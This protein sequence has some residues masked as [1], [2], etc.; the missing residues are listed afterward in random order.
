M[1][2]PTAQLAGI[3]IGTS[4]VTVV[5][6]EPGKDGMPRLLGIGTV[7]C[8]GLRKGVLV[9]LEAACEA[10]R[11]AVEEAEEM[12]GA[13]IDSAFVSVAGGHI[14][15]VNSRGAVQ[16]SGRDGEVTAEDVRRVLE[17]A[18]T[19]SIPQDREIFHVLPQEYTLDGQRGIRH[20]LGMAG[21]RLSASV[22]LVTGSTPTIQNVV[23]CVNKVGIA[24]ADIVLGQIASAEAVLSPDERELGVLLIDIGGGTTDV[25]VFERDVIWHTSVLPAGG[26]NFTNDI[27]V[28]LRTPI[29][30]AERIKI[31]Y[32]CALPDMVDSD[33]VVEVPSVGGRRGRMLSRRVLCD[34]LEPRA[35]EIFTLVAED[36]K[37]AGYEQTPHA[38]A[39]LTGGG[40][41]LE[42]L[43]AV[44]E[45]ALGLP[46]R[47][48]VPERVE[49]LVDV[50]AHPVHATAA[51]L[52]AFGARAGTRR[53]RP[54]VMPGILNNVGRRVRD[55]LGVHF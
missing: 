38:G 51:G 29:P 30:D 45:K 33:A 48:G 39:V 7:P 6:G 42:G 36:V 17:A 8:R 3:D 27:A 37:H 25:A 47:R 22:H 19:V 35:E 26:D 13:D 24:V 46:V 32:G 55:W 43:T 2:K 5:I 44:A 41:L 15:S 16:V 28:G 49:G 18:R 21:T 4:K 20:P 52:V 23:T 1:G 40:S 12:A 34:I 9:D 11:T 10:L 14:R 50:A 31:Q 53:R 54:A